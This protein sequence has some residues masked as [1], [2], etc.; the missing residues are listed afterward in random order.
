MKVYFQALH[1][2]LST[3][4]TCRK[5]M[6]CPTE[7]RKILLNHKTNDVNLESYIVLDYIQFIELYDKW[8]PYK[9]LNL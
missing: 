8:D 3:V 2:F 7:D 1:F 4:N 5:I 9:E 6:G